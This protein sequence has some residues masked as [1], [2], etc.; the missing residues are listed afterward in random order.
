MT[1][2]ILRFTAFAIAIAGL[3]DPA[4]PVSGFSRPRVAVVALQPVSPAADAIRDR[5]VRDLST[6]YEIVPEVTSDAAAAVVIGDRFPVDPVPDSLLIATVTTTQTIRP[7]V[8]IVR[9]D[10]PRE[11]P[12]ATVIHLDVELEGLGVSGQ[13]TDVT[14][15]IAG[16]EISRASHRWTADD[17]RWHASIN[18]VPVGESPFVLRVEAMPTLA[19]VVID[20]R[21]APFRVEFYDPRPSW[22]TTFVR[23]A[24]EADTRFQVAALSFTS[25]GISARTGGAASLADPRLD[26]FD[27]VIVGGLERLSTADAR[28]LDR[29]MRERGGAVVVMPDHRI[30]AGPARDLISGGDPDSGSVRLPAS[31]PPVAVGATARPGRSAEREGWQPDLVERLLEQPATLAVAPPAAAFSASELLLARSLPPGSDVVA[32]IP[33]TDA[34][35]VIVS[36]ARGDGRLLLSGAMDAWRFRASDNGAFDRFWQSTIAGLALAVPPPIAISVDPPLLRPGERADF[37]VRV[38]SRDVASVSASLD[39][40]QP[41]RLVPDP[42]A[43]AYSGHFVA[44]DTPGR[45]ILEVRAVAPQPISASQTLLV[46]PDVH[47]VR[48][49]AAPS[50]GML[51]TSHRGIDVNPERV[52]D[53]ERF[54]RNAVASLRAPL[55][56]HPMRS[57]WWILPFALCLSAEWWLRRRQGLR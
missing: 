2:S 44:K 11:M 31:A 39:R 8:R 46:Q 49:T 1:R 35:P 13:T 25:R 7:G 47:R 52:A 16:L 32:R 24:L 38:R 34:A 54:L 10:A 21:R 28:S 29:Y 12:P 17:E 9:V 55:V 4:I 15:A 37:T 36:M 18:A 5:L 53:L 27:V 40:D 19:D 6:S 23:R 43:G 26:A 51:A 48:S 22:A 14:A 20:V 42:E 3:V 50:L 41:I 56:R 45:S 33:G 30:E 57:T